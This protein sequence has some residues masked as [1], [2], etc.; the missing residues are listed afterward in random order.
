[1]ITP[2]NTTLWKAKNFVFRLTHPRFWVMNYKVCWKYDK[3]LYD[4][5]RE[6]ETVKH[7]GFST[8]S[9]NEDLNRVWASNYP[10]CFGHIYQNNISIEGTKNQPSPLTKVMLKKLLKESGLWN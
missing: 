7:S 2:E 8:V 10:Y 5:I 9:L 4:S 3:R 1:M 6:C